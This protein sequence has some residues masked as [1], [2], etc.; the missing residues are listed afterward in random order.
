MEIRNLSHELWEATNGTQMNFEQMSQ[1]Q[2]NAMMQA[3][4]LGM[5]QDEYEYL[6][7]QSQA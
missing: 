2:Y 7:V 3:A 6:M 5:S 4:Q 1:A